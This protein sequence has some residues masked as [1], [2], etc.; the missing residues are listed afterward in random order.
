MAGGRWLVAAGGGW[1][2]LVAGGFW[3]VAGGLFLVTGID[4][5]G[6]WRHPGP[7]SLRESLPNGHR[8]PSGTSCLRGSLPRRLHTYFFVGLRVLDGDPSAK[9][10]Q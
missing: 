4:T 6:L 5:N 10:D 9:T 7:S 2:W 3:L 1:W 8:I